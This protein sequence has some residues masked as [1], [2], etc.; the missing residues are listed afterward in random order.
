[1]QLEFLAGVKSPYVA[2][3]KEG[4]NGR[5]RGEGYQFKF[6]MSVCQLSVKWVILI[7]WRPK[8]LPSA[9]SSL[10]FWSGCTKTT[11]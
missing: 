8:T 1:M 2:K 9:V 10:I 4:L 7:N 11:Q 5:G 6:Q 3:I